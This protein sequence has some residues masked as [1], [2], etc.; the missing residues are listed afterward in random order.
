[1]T[2]ILQQVTER[3][4]EDYGEEPSIIVR[5]PGRVNLIGEHT[6][7]NDGFV[8]PMAI[9]RAVVIAL[10]PRM[11][12][13]VHIRSLDFD[14]PITFALDGLQK[15]KASPT[16]YVKGVAWALQEDGYDLAGFEGI[17]KG[18]VPIGSGLSSSAALEMAAARA[19]L[20]CIKA[21]WQP[22]KIALLGQKVENKWMGVNSGIMDQMISAAGVQDHAVL[23]DCRS[24]EIETLRLPP[25]T[26]VLI[27][28]T[29]TRRGLVDSAYNERRQQCEAAAEFFG[30]TALRDVSVEM[31]E[32]NADGLDPLIRQR[33]KHIVYENARVLEARDAM[34]KDDAEWLGRLMDASHISL[35]DD[36]EVSSDALNA[37]VD[38]T[39]KQAGVYG[40][41]MTGA[42]F[43]GCA[44]ALVDA[45]TVEHIVA[46]IAAD[47]KQKTGYDASIYVTEAANGAEVLKS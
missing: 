7:Y 47:Y 26:A 41:R 2:D 12:R 44:V 16:E 36:Y 11:D 45:A 39:R 29:S 23:I 27:L 38:I 30:V 15:G 18:D 24:L 42:G 4:V 10:R 8:M 19:F 34:L 14:Q 37:I 35:R 43:G 28:D 6:D 3:F 21:D 32:A 31:F 17:M 5:A 46:P 22:A 40:A 33:A 20:A 1:M 13:T 9:N 25:G